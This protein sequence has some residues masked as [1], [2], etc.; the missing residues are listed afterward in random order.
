MKISII[1][2]VYNN[3]ESLRELFERIEKIT[4]DSIFTNHSFELICV[5]DGSRDNS[6]KVLQLLATKTHIDCKIIH[7]T[8]NFGSYNAFLAGMCHANGAC[9]I[10]LHADL[11]DP[12][13]LIPKLFSHYLNGYKLVIANRENREDSSLFSSIYHYLVKRFAIQNTPTG[14]F[15]LILFNEEIRKEIVAISEKHTNNVYLINWL[16]YE[17]VNVPYKRVKRKYGK[18]QWAFWKKVRLFVDTF[19]SFSNIPLSLIRI[20]FY[21]TFIFF[22]FTFLFVCFKNDFSFDTPIFYFSIGLLFLGINFVI[23][24]EYLSRIHE[25]VRNRPNFV[26]QKIDAFSNSKS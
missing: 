22:I 5:N 16:G 26:V 3:E 12:P 18:S 25:T 20:G 9:N 17:Y 19:F 24:G 11:Q 6:R 10:H 4:E 23:I 1:I 21:A 8:R 13:E 14:G 2:P 7:L 15:D